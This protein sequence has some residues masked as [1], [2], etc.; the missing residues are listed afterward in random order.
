MALPPLRIEIGADP[1][2][3]VAGLERVQTEAMQT[4]KAVDAMGQQMVVANKR[5][6]TAGGGSRRFGSQIQNASYQV[7]DFSVQIA[8]GTSATVALSQQL[9]QLLGGFGMMGAVLGGLVSV[10]ALVVQQLT[11]TDSVLRRLMVSMDIMSAKSA[12]EASARLELLKDKA[13][14]YKKEL[15]ELGAQEKTTSAIRRASE[16]L[17]E[18]S[19]TR[20][21]PQ[22]Q[23]SE[24]AKRAKE[25]REAI[26]RANEAV[27]EKAAAENTAHGAAVERAK[28]RIANTEREIEETERLIKFYKAAESGQKSAPADKQ[29]GYSKD[30]RVLTEDGGESAGAA[31]PTSQAYTIQLQNR[32]KALEQFTMTEQEMIQNR[33]ADRHATLV[34][35]LANELLT[36]KEF[37]D[38]S[39]ALREKQAQDLAAIQEA[40]SRKTTNATAN[41]FGAMATLAESGG[42]KMAGLAKGFAIAEA[43][44][45]TYAGATRA[46]K[47]HPF[48][49]SAAIASTVIA[50]GLAN[51]ASIMAV[52]T[53]GSGS[54]TPSGGGA[55][56][57]AA[58][59]QPLEVTLSGFG[60]NDLFT[61]SQLSGLFDKLQD[62]AGDRGVTF[63]RVAA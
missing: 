23:L 39:T 55:A 24:A 20:K 32:L 36:E 19:G 52:N 35:A 6:A 42:K 4:G 29:K 9:P 33:Y 56:T 21:A 43:I 47:D 13:A 30:S 15:K 44:V 54:A 61:G 1:T 5:M 51:I 62:E 53:S 8:S 41:M 37:L 48:P 38:Q 46:F 58:A 17:S 27:V 3:A 40:N 16:K 59:P 7:Q 31:D 12:T 45:N 22:P 11:T 25:E 14:Q 57:A 60:P 2:Q 10:I 26:T 63:A 18:Q 49:L 28:E 50:A 34:E